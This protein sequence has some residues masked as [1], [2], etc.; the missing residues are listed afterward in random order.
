MM[1]ALMGALALFGGAATAQTAQTPRSAQAAAPPSPPLV[2]DPADDAAWLCRP[3]RDDACAADRTTTLLPARGRPVVV[4]HRPAE[5]PKVDCFY[6]YPTV[7]LD[8]TGNSDLTPGP[9]ERNA[10]AQQFARFSGLCRPFAPVHRQLTL[11]ALRGFFAGA[12]IPADVNLPYEDVR[13]AWRHYLAND[14][15]GRGV[16]LIGHSQGAGVL[17]RLI[18]EEIDGKP[19]H[20]QVIAAYLAGHAIAVPD[21]RDVGGDFQSMPLCRSAREAGCVV[22][23]ASFR[24]E[25]GRPA[26]SLFGVVN[27]RPGL[28]AACVNPAA[29]AGGAAPLRPE[30]AVNAH[31]SGAIAPAVWPE[32]A[33]PP[34]TPFMAPQGLLTGRCVRVGEASYLAVTTKTTPAPGQPADLGGDL[35]A[36][37]AKLPAWGLHMVDMHLVMGDLVALADAQSKAWLK[38]RR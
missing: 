34:A 4:R 24:E 17:K 21:G 5:A 11:A 3:G 10:A 35:L 7:S 23:W 26:T 12:P 14:N 20:L 2:F 18:A 25:V 6:V 29:L 30:W 38:T 13:A 19:V 16:I 15:G 32:G 37:G 8:P 33:S 27:G 22:T 28:V 31:A 9:E 36:F 1:A